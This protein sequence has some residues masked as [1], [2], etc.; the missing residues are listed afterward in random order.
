M[1]G[2]YNKM[3]GVVFLLGFLTAVSNQANTHP[4]TSQS[5]FNKGEN[6]EL[7]VIG[8][9]SE[10]CSFEMK[11][12]WGNIPC[13]YIHEDREDSRG[14]LCGASKQPD[15]CRQPGSGDYHLEE[16]AGESGWCKLRL[17]DARFSDEGVYKITFLS[18]PRSNHE[19][20][21]KVKQTIFISNVTV[22]EGETIE[23][24]SA[25]GFAGYGCSFE[26]KNTE[27]NLTCCY[28]HEGREDNRGKKLCSASKQPDWCRQPGSG[29][30]KVEELV[31]WCKLTL[32]DA[33]LSDT[34]V[35]KIVFPFEPDRYNQETVMVNWVDSL[36]IGL[37]LAYCLLWAG[38]GVV[39]L[40]C[41]VSCVCT[42]AEACVA[43]AKAKIQ[44]RR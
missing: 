27:K 26:M 16:F 19:I 14:K 15:E 39:L 23:L 21:V 20:A 17:V 3:C 37:T 12:K 31:G 43:K 40:T 11:E 8:N 5:I 18:E 9:T 44:S 30:Y 1:K 22:N 6:I 41:F 34:G 25:G 10:G 7:I 2:K 33:K 13:C 29:E 35:Y 36:K 32:Y 4:M 28:I 38:A 42:C 24:K